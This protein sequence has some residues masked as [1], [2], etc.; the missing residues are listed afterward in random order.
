MKGLPGPFLVNFVGT[1]D[2]ARYQSE[3]VTEYRTGERTGSGAYAIPDQG[4]E[5]QPTT[6]RASGLEYARKEKGKME[7]KKRT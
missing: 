2:W 4:P 6:T 1:R 7:V 5:T 3:L